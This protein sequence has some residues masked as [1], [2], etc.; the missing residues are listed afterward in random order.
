ML[1][2]QN[3]GSQKKPK[4]SRN[5]QNATKYEVVSKSLSNKNIR[6]RRNILINARCSIRRK[7][8]KD[9]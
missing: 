7:E 5:D 3:C 2:Y 8:P 4:E 9:P 6:L 1:L